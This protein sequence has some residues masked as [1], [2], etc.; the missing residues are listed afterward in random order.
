MKF[1]LFYLVTGLL[2]GIIVGFGSLDMNHSG[3]KASPASRIIIALLMIVGWAVA[4]IGVDIFVLINYFRKNKDDEISDEP[5]WISLEDLKPDL[6]KKFEEEKKNSTTEN[7]HID[8]SEEE[9]TED[10][11]TK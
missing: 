9:K 5:V 7:T 1:I 10:S 4:L 6:A 2:L 3:K 8:I 11:S